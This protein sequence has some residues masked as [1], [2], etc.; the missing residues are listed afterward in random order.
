MAVNLEWYV[1]PRV[2]LLR[3]VDRWEWTDLYES[4]GA[5]C[6]IADSMAPARV[7]TILDF[8][9]SRPLPEGPIITHLRNGAFHARPNN[10]FI[11]IVGAD[12]VVKSFVKMFDK[13]YPALAGH[14]RLADDVEEAMVV[15]HLDRETEANAALAPDE[16]IPHRAMLAMPATRRG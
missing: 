15:I 14:Y 7:D 6:D 2:C 4:I 10:G 3:C 12:R 5:A 11:V 13:V 8:K 16:T 9:P 1:D